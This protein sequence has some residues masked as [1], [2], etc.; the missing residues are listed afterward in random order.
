MIFDP[1]YAADAITWAVVWSG[2]GLVG[3][4]LLAKHDR[5]QQREQAAGTARK[6]GR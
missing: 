6:A 5:R 3:R 4:Q 2:V 1:T